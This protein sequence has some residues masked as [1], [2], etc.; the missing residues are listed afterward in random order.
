[1]AAAGVAAAAH[2]RAAPGVRVLREAHRAR[3]AGDVRLPVR[4]GRRAGARH[5][6]ARRARGQGE[7][8]R[9][10]ALRRSAPAAL[11]RLRAGARPGRR[12][13]RRADRGAGPAGAAQ[14]VGRAARDPGAGQDDRLHHALPGRGGDP[15]R[16]RGDHGRGPDPRHG[17]ADEPGPRPRRADPGHP[18]ARPAVHFG[19]GGAA[20]RRRR[21]R[22]RRVADDRPPARRPTC[23]ARSPNAARSP[24]CRCAP[25]PSRT[26]S[27]T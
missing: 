2:R 7:H 24:G 19:R 22:G 26:S 9:G 20:R 3:A 8:P 17:H 23:S 13:P 27:S 10:Q 25:P 21:R 14:P 5:A 16:P 6:G 1:M 4:R 12:L 18:R 11:D 15:L